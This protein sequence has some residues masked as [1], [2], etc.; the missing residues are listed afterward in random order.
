[1][2]TSKYLWWVETIRQNKFRENFPIS[3]I[4]FIAF[5]ICIITF[6]FFITASS[7]PIEIRNLSLG[8]SF[9]S[10]LI[11]MVLLFLIIA[12]SKKANRD[13]ELVKQLWEN[14]AKENENINKELL[15]YFAMDQKPK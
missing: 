2:K 6:I 7:L 12:S 3:I 10:A 9:I 1:M 13:I 15:W 8:V 5:L 4:M 14:K 11:M